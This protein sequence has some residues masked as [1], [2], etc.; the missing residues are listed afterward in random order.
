MM[1]IRLSSPSKPTTGRSTL[2]TP[3][4]IDNAWGIL[5]YRQIIN[6]LINFKLLLLLN[7]LASISMK[8]TDLTE[9][10]YLAVQE[11]MAHLSAFSE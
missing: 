10:D 3:N 7:G 1:Q 9:K 2:R 6:N 11:L 8:S 4:R 5:V